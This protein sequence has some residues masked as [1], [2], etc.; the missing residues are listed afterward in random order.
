MR[1]MLLTACALTYALTSH[2]QV[3]TP[4]LKTKFAEHHVGIQVNELVKQIFS[5]GNGAAAVTNP[6]LLTYNINHIKTG[7]GVRLGAGYSSQT[8]SNED[9]VTNRKTDMNKLNLRFGFEKSFKLS[10][11]WTAGAGADGIYTTDYDHTETVV[12]SF[13][14]TS[15]STIV[16]NEGFG[17]GAM[18]WLRYTVTKNIVIGTE[19]SF[20]NTTVKQN[21]EVTITKRTTNFPPK[22]VTTVNKLDNT[23]RQTTL[24]LPVVLYL[25]IR[26]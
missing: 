8:L 26:F 18:A 22:L 5:L 16:K 11:R 14:T 21:Q 6:Y 15:T 7:I 4:K 1:K 12:R 2:A 24:S 3:D 23:N 20:Y 19:A 13:D 10:G 9:G 17:Y 25:L